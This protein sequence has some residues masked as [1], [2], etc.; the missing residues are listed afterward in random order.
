LTARDLNL[1]VPLYDE[2]AYYNDVRDRWTG[3]GDY[4]TDQ[5]GR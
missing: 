3:T 1:P 4:A 2:T 5:P